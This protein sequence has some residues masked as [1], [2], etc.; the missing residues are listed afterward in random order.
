MA[1]REQLYVYEKMTLVLNG[2]ITS[3]KLFRYH[4]VHSVASLKTGLV[5]NKVHFVGYCTS[6]GWKMIRFLL[7]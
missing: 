4:F 2:F 6:R 1:S 5:H 3:K 7:L